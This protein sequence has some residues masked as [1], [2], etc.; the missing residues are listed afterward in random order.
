MIW[1]YDSHTSTRAVLHR[2]RAADP[3]LTQRP[4]RAGMITSKLVIDAGNGVD[5]QVSG[6]AQEGNGDP[7]AC[8]HAHTHLAVVVAALRLRCRALLC[9]LLHPRH[10]RRRS[11]VW[12]M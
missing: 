1:D 2:R 9:T 10:A 7:H 5:A 8:L 11:R 12:C 3:V 4:V 6:R